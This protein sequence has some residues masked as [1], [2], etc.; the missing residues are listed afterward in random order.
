MRTFLDDL[1]FAR[2]MFARRRRFAFLL[3]ATIGVGIGA[4]TSI[5]S[6]VDTVLWKPLPYRDADRLYWIARTDETWRTSPVLASV[7]DNMG[8]ALPDYRQW[9]DAQRSFE[10]TAAWF[11]TN[12]VLA[13][14]D[15]LEQ[16]STARATASLTP[17]L[18]VQPALGRWFVP[19]EDDRNGPRLAVLSFETWQ[20]RY[21]RSAGIVGTRLTLNGQPFEV[22]GVL[23]GGFR[24]AGD[25][26]LVEV[27]T[28][29]G[30][31]PA[32]WQ[33]NN[34]NFRVF[35][36]LR[37]GTTVAS[38]IDEATRL[39]GVSDQPGRIG[40]RLENLQAETIKAVKAPLTILLW[41][42]VL[43]LIVACGNVGTLL[44]GE[45]AARDVEISTRVSLGATQG[46]VTRQLLTE[47]LLLAT[48]GGIDR[49]RGSDRAG[50][51]ASC[52]RAGRHPADRNRACRWPSAPVRYDRERAGGDCLLRRAA[53]HRVARVSGGDDARRLIPPH[54]TARLH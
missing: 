30:I 50:S 20:T 25:T 10:A 21:G 13:T 36:R 12:G 38:A 31:S 54:A 22:I 39:L 16:I 26:T 34:F 46:R 42:A 24:V 28:P 35:G 53:G 52:D 32:D 47:H 5:F 14:N 43:L 17:M 9:A 7:W 48:L 37:R 15:G 1:R 41:S 8:H 45:T 27:W 11:A 49:M 23:P 19:G 40:I 51:G 33:R 29:A 6:I 4:A 3:V 18:G 2:R 44:V